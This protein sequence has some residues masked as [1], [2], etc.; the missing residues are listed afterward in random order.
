MGLNFG[1]GSEDMVISCTCG[2]KDVF[3]GRCIDD[4]IALAKK[5]VGKLF[6]QIKLFV[7][8]AIKLKL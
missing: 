5:K 6:R 3:D 1:C 7:K 4:C 2:R 8:N